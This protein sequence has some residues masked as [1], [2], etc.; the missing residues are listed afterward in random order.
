MNGTTTLTIPGGEPVMNVADG[1]VLD[2]LALN[3]NRPHEPPS[4]SAV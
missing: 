3:E 2:D 4:S 1:K